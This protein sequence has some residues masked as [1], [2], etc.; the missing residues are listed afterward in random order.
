MFSYQTLTCTN[1]EIVN[2]D[3]YSNTGKVK[4]VN[5]TLSTPCMQTQ[6]SYTRRWMEMVN[7]RP[8]PLYH[9]E[10]TSVP[11]GYET[12]WAPES[13]CTILRGRKSLAPVGMRT[14]QSSA[15]SLVTIPTVLSRVTFSNS[16]TQ[17]LRTAALF[18]NSKRH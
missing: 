9:R 1:A 14:E 6:Y 7:I 3:S 4:K 18:Q 11:T 8:Q 12:E 15:R 5:S 2:G 13:V 16:C 10:R 17:T